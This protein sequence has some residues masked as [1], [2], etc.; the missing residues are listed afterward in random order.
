M[1]LV[2][3]VN[4]V[5]TSTNTSIFL[6]STTGAYK[7]MHDYKN[8][9]QEEKK[10]VL[11]RDCVILGGSA[12]GIAGYTVGKANFAKSGFR[13]QCSGYI[14]KAITSIK[15]TKFWQKTHT[16]K[17][18]PIK[19]KSK[20]ILNHSKEIA[21]ECADNTL[22]VAAGIT[23]AVTS[24]YLIQMSHLSERILKK[25]VTNKT[26]L[27]VDVVQ[28]ENKIQ[29][30]DKNEAKQNT[31]LTNQI[32]NNN[33]NTTN[34]PFNLIKKKLDVD[35]ET[36]DN[37]FSNIGNMQEMKVFNNAFVGLESFHIAEEKTFKDKL[38]ETTKSLVAKTL[39]PVFFLSLASNLTRGM[40]LIYRV[41]L[42]FASLSAGMIATD[43]KLEKAID[44]KMA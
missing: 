37:I 9:S 5:L 42:V 34:S 22:L 12:L 11:L 10:S 24:D 39:V 27:N 19:E 16:E 41:P 30:F 20:L 23:G 43:K 14:D 44:K 25:H 29:E 28:N 18:K 31:N 13:K 36:K 17:A 2:N 8:A 1:G 35:Q 6:F 7:I 21:K 4:H 3:Q 15:N 32:T 38:R 40:K 26:G 33:K